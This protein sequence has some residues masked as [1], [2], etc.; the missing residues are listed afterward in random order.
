MNVESFD[1]H[2]QSAI[3]DFAFS[4]KLFFYFHKIWINI[5]HTKKFEIFNKKDIIVSFL[6]PKISSQLITVTNATNND[7]AQIK[8]IVEKL[9]ALCI[10]V[11]N[12][13]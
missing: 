13:F 9:N 12:K 1:K 7:E 2:I 6:H 5:F 3:D 8:I 11:R 10:L 4:P